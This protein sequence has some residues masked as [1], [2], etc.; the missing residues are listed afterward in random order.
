MSY[1]FIFTSCIIHAK[2][3]KKEAVMKLKKD[4]EKTERTETISFRVSPKER[5]LIELLSSKENSTISQYIIRCIVMDMLTS[6]N[7]EAMKYA[8]SR[9][10]IGVRESIKELIHG[11]EESGP[12]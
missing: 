8:V 4:T 2:T 6:G 11:K 5:R 7:A 12:A 3:L 10:G 9:F 1:I